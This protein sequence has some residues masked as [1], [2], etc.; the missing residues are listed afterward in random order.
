MAESLSSRSAKRPPNGEVGKALVR[1][2]AAVNLLMGYKGESSLLCI[3]S[4]CPGPETHRSNIHLPVEGA[5]DPP[6]EEVQTDV[7][8][9]SFLRLT[10]IAQALVLL[11]ADDDMQGL[12]VGAAGTAA[13]ATA[14]VAAILVCMIDDGKP[15][16]NQV[17]AGATLAR[18]EGEQLETAHAHF[19]RGTTNEVLDEFIGTLAGMLVF[20]NC[21]VDI[22]DGSRGGG[23][24]GGGGGGRSDGIKCNMDPSGRRLLAC[25]YT[26]AWALRRKRDEV[27]AQAMLHALKPAAQEYRSYQQQLTDHDPSSGSRDPRSMEERDAYREFVF[28]LEPLANLHLTISLL[29][30]HPFL[31][32]AQVHRQQALEQLLVRGPR[33]GH[34]AQER[35]GEAR[36]ESGPVHRCRPPGS[37]AAHAPVRAALRIP[38]A[39]LPL[40]ETRWPR[41]KRSNH[42]A[43]RECRCGERPCGERR[44]GELEL[45]RDG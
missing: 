29:T 31:F 24:G 23:G 34:E 8:Q 18:F 43:H 9:L 22:C 19:K 42:R 45:G 36:E 30:T 40:L 28:L 14:A 21:G 25:L 35:G 44:C 17:W 33:Q 32:R 15:L 39:N 37:G 20:G 12:A 38:H 41:R 5:I 7:L 10:K 2:A 13:T 27:G 26:A 3:L 16:Y 4:H 11:A 6:S 1:I